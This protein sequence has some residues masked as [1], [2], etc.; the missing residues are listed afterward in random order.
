MVAFLV[1]DNH[2]NQHLS[3]VRFDDRWLGLTE[4]LW[5][6]REGCRQDYAER[7]RWPRA[8]H[9]RLGDAFQETCVTEG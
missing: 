1:R 5:G 7:Q 6:D 8:W 4:S 3:H 9:V 2:R